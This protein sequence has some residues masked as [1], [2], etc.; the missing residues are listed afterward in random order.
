M[1]SFN[2]YPVLTQ[3][4][5]DELGYSTTLPQFS[6]TEGDQSFDLS[7]KHP[8]D[9]ILSLSAELE[10]PRCHFELEKNDIYMDRNLTISCPDALF[11]P[12]GI[13]T[14]KSV[15]GVAAQWISTKSEHRGVI[16]IGEF[17]LQNEKIEL[18]YSHMFPA[19]LIRGSLVIH[20]ILYLKTPGLAEPNEMMLCQKSGTVLGELDGF[21]IHVEGNG[22]IFP[23]VTINDESKPLWTVY[24]DDTS[25]P[26]QD[27]FD[28]DH[29]EI[30]LNK[31]HPNY[32][33]L[34]IDSSLKESPLFLE[35][36]SSALMI[37][38]ESA[39]ENLGPDWD[40]VISGQMQLEHGTIAEA[41]YY[42]VSKLGWDTTS[43]SRLAQSIH[44]FFDASLSG[45]TL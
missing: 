45:G 32:E 6:Y 18:H 16:P 30:R 15:I 26:L 42:F 33:A 21:E 34:K 3:S 25:D 8:S 2:M 13:V 28:E 7:L 40:A 11:G 4:K 5:F 19:N 44:S 27:L 31:A 20:T 22:S 14:Q 37:I 41:V 35:V 23:I 24:Y 1:E 38:I 29:V 9:N 12:E 36:M 17:S 10:D 43:P 39:K